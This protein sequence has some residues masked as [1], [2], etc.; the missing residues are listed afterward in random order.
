MVFFASEADCCGMFVFRGFGF[1]GTVIFFIESCQ[2]ESRGQLLALGV[3]LSLRLDQ[4][5]RS[6]HICNKLALADMFSRVRSPHLV[7][8]STA[9]TLSVLVGTLGVQAGIELAGSL[10]MCKLASFGLA[11]GSIAADWHT[12][13]LELTVRVG[14]MR[15]EPT[16]GLG[17]VRG[18]YSW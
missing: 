15:E 8:V 10:D 1:F 17:L 7:G 5:L 2:A 4:L 14:A 6:I 9:L 16:H 11:V 18:S 3:L 13:V 12:R